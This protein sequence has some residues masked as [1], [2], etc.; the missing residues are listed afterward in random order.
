[1]ASIYGVNKSPCRNLFSPWEKE[2]TEFLHPNHH[3][4]RISLCVFFF[5]F[6]FCLFVCL[7]WLESDES[8]L[9]TQA[10]IKGPLLLLQTDKTGPD[11]VTIQLFTLF[12]LFFSPRYGILQVNKCLDVV[13]TKCHPR[14]WCGG[15]VPRYLPTCICGGKRHLV[16]FSS[17]FCCVCLSR[18]SQKAVWTMSTFAPASDRRD[19]VYY[20]LFEA[21]RRC[22]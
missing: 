9:D 15:R 6:F 20:W 10:L 22:G 3:I 7:Q 14:D 21:S 11:D 16:W 19:D 17:P 8:A 13:K 12:F 1:M 4:H 5:L 18:T 2:M